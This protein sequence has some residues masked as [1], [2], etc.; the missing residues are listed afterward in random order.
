MLK[1]ERLDKMLTQCLLTSKSRVR[2]QTRPT[3]GV[4]VVINQASQSG[5]RVSFQ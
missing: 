1:I 4:I 3:T 5:L 2:D